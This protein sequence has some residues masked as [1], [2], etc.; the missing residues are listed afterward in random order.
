[1]IDT[2]H[3]ETHSFQKLNPDTV[4]NLAEK[5]LDRQFTNLFRPLNSYINRV[6]E[7][8]DFHGNEVIGK[9]YR[10]GRWRKETIQDE[11]DFLL[12]LQSHEIPVI[13]PLFLK[14][15]TTLA[16]WEDIFFAF[17]PKCGGRSVD[18]LLDD[19]WQE[20]G[21][22]IGRVHAV[23]AMSPA[24]HRITMKPSESSSF[25]INYLR[26][27]DLV[28][29]EIEREFFSIAEEMVSVTDTLFEKTPFQRIHGDL[30]L[31]NIIY[32]PGESFVL[33]DFDDMVM[34]PKI[35]DLWML[36]PDYG[37][38][39]VYELESFLEG[40]ETFHT[41]SRKEY[42]LIEPLRAMRYIHYLAW[43]GHQVIED[44][45]T[46]VIPD[47]GTYAFWRRETDELADQIKRIGALL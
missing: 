28:P 22:L 25:H 19:H 40:Y 46:Q 17:Y 5:F 38:K 15:G 23:G 33:I 45:H 11:H 29:A 31:A 36:L 9:F 18:E 37:E 16:C 4:I 20:L 2:T 24:A 27:N 35:Q 6:F 44:G 13:A 30:H 1:M 21:R 47:Y 14:D 42:M 8:Q 39:S 12:E 3:C 7:L 41:I 32:R 26:S 10:P 34:G 43:C